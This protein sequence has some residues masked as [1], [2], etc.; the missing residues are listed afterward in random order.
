[1]GLFSFLFDTDT[2]QKRA[3]AYPGFSTFTETVS[4]SVKTNFDL[5]GVVTIDED[6]AIDA[7]VDGRKQTDAVHF[8][9]NVETNLITFTSSVNVG[10]FVE[11][12]IYSK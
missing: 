7:W 10:S 9:R 5:T 8:N 4:G 2:H 12:R 3:I 6:H 1:M 11:I